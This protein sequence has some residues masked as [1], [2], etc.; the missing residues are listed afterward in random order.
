VTDGGTRA[1][2]A[3]DVPPPRP[4]DAGGGRPSDPAA[5]PA[6]SPLAR[7]GRAVAEAVAGLLESRGADVPDDGPD[8][9]PRGGRGAAAAAGLRDVVGALVG[10]LAGTRGAEPED[11]PR[12]ADAPPGQRAPTAL[13]GDLLDAAAP[14]LPVRDRDRIRAAHPGRTD[15]EIAEALT[16]RASR[17]TTGIGAATGGLAA[18][19][20]FAPPSMLAVPLEIGAETVLVAAVEVVLVGELHEL[21]GHRPAGDARERA[22]A[23]LASWTARRGLTDGRTGL[24]ATLGSAG[25]LAVRRAVT[26]RLVRAVPSAAPFMIGAALGGRSNRKATESLAARLVEDLRPPRRA[27]GRGPS[28]R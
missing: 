15:D 9:A 24:G 10:A 13:L 18:M 28:D 17:L 3:R 20:W 21:Y 19:H 26:R 4:V 14:R 5:D 22:S 8:A 12:I 16:T 27:L 11:G 2:A 7:A 1:G 23:Y 25:L 6:G